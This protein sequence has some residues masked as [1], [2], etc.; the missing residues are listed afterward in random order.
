MNKDILVQKY[1][2]KNILCMKICI[3]CISMCLYLH[4]VNMFIY[5]YVS[6]FCV[7]FFNRLYSEFQKL[8]E[9]KRLQLEANNP[10]YEDALLAQV[11]A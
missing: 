11:R 2:Y 7:R 5:T 4:V 1:L 10:E 3:T 6:M 9:I 8:L